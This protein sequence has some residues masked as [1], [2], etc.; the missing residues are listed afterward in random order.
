MTDGLEVGKRVLVQFGK[1]KFYSALIRKIHHQ[2]PFD[3]TPKLIET[4]L[5]E[6]PLL[7]E[8][9]LEFW[10][11][12]ASY[13]LCTVGEVMNASL[14]A[15]LK[16]SSETTLVMHPDFSGDMQHLKDDEYMIGEA[17]S[18]SK[19][20][21]I[22]DLQKITGRK[23]VYPIIRSLIDH[24][25]ALFHEEV[26]EVY[27]P[28]V[29]TFVRLTE[30][31]RDKTNLKILFDELGR[32]PKQLEMLMHYLRLSPKYEKVRKS[33]LTKESGDSG[34]LVK[35][36]A[37]KEVFEESR[38]EVSRLTEKEIE[39]LSHFELNE[40]QSAAYAEMQEIYKQKSVVLL[41]GVT[42][43]GKT[44]LYFKLI[45][46]QIEAGKQVLFLLP[47]ISLTVQLIQR[48][49]AVFGNQ[50][51]VYH[52]RYSQNERV[53]IWHKTLKQEYK[54][55]VGAR[56]AIFLP[57]PSLGLIIVDEEHDASFKQSEPDPKYQARDASIILAHRHGA[58][59][60]LGSATPS[61]ESRRNAE[62]GRYGIVH[63]NNRYQG[64]KMPIIHLVDMKEARE[65]KQLYTHFSFKLINAIKEA[66]QKK[67]QVILLQN[68]RGYS[69]YVTCQTCGWIPMCHQCDISLTYHKYADYLACHYCGFKTKT[70]T[71][72]QA[73]GSATMIIKGFGTEKVED[74]LQTLLPGARI[75][76]LD[77][78]A[79]KKKNAYEEILE[80]FAQRETDILVGTQMISKGLDFDNV[81]MVGVL[82]ADQFLFFPEFRATERAFQLILQVSGRAG[83]KLRQG[84][85]YVQTSQVTHPIFS[86]VTKHDY[87]GFYANE[88]FNRKQFY[89]PPFC[90]LIEIEVKHKEAHVVES[91]SIDLA[92]ILRKTLGKRVLGPTIPS[93]SKIRNYYIRDLL[94][95]IDRAKDSPED[96]KRFL[97]TGIEEMKNKAEY[98]S[99]WVQ[100]NVDP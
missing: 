98:K 38:E 17:L 19:K 24:G 79:A 21:E 97:I 26:N 58:K 29:E 62:L 86:F 55:I 33:T 59:T 70:R 8:R 23:N 32:A 10:E 34:A 25:V 69:S 83:R 64:I 81:S 7:H 3:V 80:R 40:E 43:S 11:W 78:D 93:V 54:I 92:I 89:Y 88:I 20:L 4:I 6:K 72:C 9:E 52:S 41:E 16:L 28:K 73:C 84:D 48:L 31:Y 91:A 66:L 12:I 60:L 50:V 44:H 46:E 76:R 35:R 67:E 30:F 57:F 39:S 36:L 68:R 13:Y 63:L 75:D 1:Q 61:L 85:V 100:C 22:R 96:V 71:K 18:I 90:R 87:F 42:G 49:Q 37:E 51:G 14:P 77:W 95:K 65:S 53:E 45:Q 82:N 27:K 99:V 94:I 47:E 2:K 56:S 5:D 15:A 74:D